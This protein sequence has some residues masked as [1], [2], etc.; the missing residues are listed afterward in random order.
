MPASNEAT[1]NM[2]DSSSSYPSGSYE[3]ISLDELVLFA[4]KRIL[5]SGEDC[6]AERLVCEC[7]T[8]FPKSFCLPRYPQWPDSARTL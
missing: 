2:S 8:L 5:D 3:H 6:T 7:F 1:G 4:V